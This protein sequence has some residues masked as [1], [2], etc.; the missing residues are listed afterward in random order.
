MAIKKE[1]INWTK[2][3]R[4]GDLDN[5][6]LIKTDSGEFTP[7]QFRELFRVDAGQFNKLFYKLLDENKIFIQL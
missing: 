2:P 5:A 7:F 1:V 6:K 4:L 3:E